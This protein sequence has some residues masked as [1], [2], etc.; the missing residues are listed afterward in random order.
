MAEEIINKPN[1]LYTI[2]DEEIALKY[3]RDEVDDVFR[4]ACKKIASNPQY[5]EE[6][7]QIIKQRA[8]HLPQALS[9]LAYRADIND[10]DL[11]GPFIQDLTVMDKLIDSI[12]TE[13]NIKSLTDTYSEK[14]HDL[15]QVSAYDYLTDSEWRKTTG[16]LIATPKNLISIYLAV[17]NKQALSAF[18]ELFIDTDKPIRIATAR[19]FLA[20]EDEKSIEYLKVGILDNQLQVRKLC[21]EALKNIVGEEEME[22]ILTEEKEKLDSVVKTIKEALQN[23]KE[24][25]KSVGTSLPDILMDAVKTL[26]DTA[27]GFMSNLKSKF[28]RSNA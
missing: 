14:E 26:A 23:I 19:Y 21:R 12:F 9:V 6:V 27:S 3:A 17:L 16:E 22:K 7:L 1:E 8:A 11:I 10:M 18:R 20:M 25:M 13:E 5:T 4:D 28:T 24:T 2:L 15:K